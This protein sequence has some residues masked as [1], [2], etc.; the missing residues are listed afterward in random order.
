MSSHVPKHKKT[1]TLYTLLFRCWT[2][3]ECDPCDSH[4]KK[5]ASQPNHKLHTL[6]FSQTGVM[7]Y[8][9]FFFLLYHCATFLPVGGDVAKC[10]DLKL[11]SKE[12]QTRLTQFK[13]GVTFVFVCTAYP[14]WE[15]WVQ[16]LGL[17]PGC[18]GD[19]RGQGSPHLLIWEADL[20]LKQIHPQ[21]WI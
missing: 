8:I 13:I 2:S 19:H 16:W 15:V 1:H 12:A 7:K 10:S 21:I 6:A 4:I 5:H 18:K 14:V 9:F 11:L 20:N 3:A 17:H